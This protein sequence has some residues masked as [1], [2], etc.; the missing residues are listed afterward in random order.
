MLKQTFPLREHICTQLETSE[1]RLNYLKQQYKGET[2]YI[3]GSGPSFS[4]Y[5]EEFLN[6]FLQDKLVI[7]IK[8][9]YNTVPDHVDFHLINFCNLNAYN[10]TK[11]GTIVGWTVW[12]NSQPSQIIN[13]RFRCDYILDVY[14]LGD[15]TPNID[16]SIAVQEDYNRVSMDYS[17]SR[18]WGPGMMYELAI[19]LAMYL[20]CS[21]VVTLGWDLFG[22]AL[23]K[24][25]HVDEN[26]GMLQDHYFSDI[27]FEQTRTHVSK[28][29]ITSVIKSTEGFYNWMQ[30]QGVDLE[31][32]D[33]YGNNPAFTGIPRIVL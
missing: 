7:S 33:P 27:T 6:E 22:N 10:Y 18:P 14:K 25:E 21:K 11:P 9:T 15:G 26:K 20:G 2:A 29:E 31:I 23:Q 5:S 4:H 28:K 32:V 3:L 13:N 17:L 19:P 8:Q 12:D 16:N 30:S 1:D 24:Y